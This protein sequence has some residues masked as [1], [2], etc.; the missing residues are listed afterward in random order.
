MTYGKDREINVVERLVIGEGQ[1]PCM[2]A[3]F[4][5]WL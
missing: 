1:E 4:N 2:L 5:P 3:Q